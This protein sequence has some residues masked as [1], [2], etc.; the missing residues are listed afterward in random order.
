M[1]PSILASLFVSSALADDT[2]QVSVEPAPAENTASP[3]FSGQYAQPTASA[4]GADFVRHGFRAGYVYANNADKLGVLDSPN[5]F[6]MGYEAEFRIL[7]DQGLDFVIVPNVMILGM[8]QGLFIPTTNALIGLSY[9]D[10]VKVGVGGNVTPSV[11]GS[12]V[13]MVAAVE[14]A[15]S[16]GKLQLPVALSFIPDNHDNWRVGLTFGV[17][18][19]KKG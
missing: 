7:G 11:N 2:L 1:V 14:V 5:L 4:H 18:W 3:T 17:N 13:H 12:W 16:V 8:N 9:N 15:P 10:F 6:A 19:P